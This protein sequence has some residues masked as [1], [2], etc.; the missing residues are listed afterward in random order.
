MDLFHDYRWQEFG[1]CKCR[2]VF[3]RRGNLKIPIT[4]LC[5]AL[6]DNRLACTNRREF[7]NSFSIPLYIRA[8]IPLSESARVNLLITSGGKPGNSAREFGQL[9]KNTR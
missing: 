4:L 8:V 1:S 5:I 6:M 9:L 7:S 3:S 2:H